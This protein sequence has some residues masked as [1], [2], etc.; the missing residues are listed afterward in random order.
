MSGGYFDHL[1]WNV[2]DLA[3]RV[4]EKLLDIELHQ[5]DTNTVS[6][7]VNAVVLLKKAAVYAER[8]DYLLSGDDGE[9]S[10]HERLADD[11]SNIETPS[12]T[13]TGMEHIYRVD[14]YGDDDI[15]LNGVTR[16]RNLIGGRTKD[17]ARNKVF[18]MFQ[19][20]TGYKTLDFMNHYMYELKSHLTNSDSYGS[21]G[22][23]E[24]CVQYYHLGERT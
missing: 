6:E 19:E 16:Y 2:E 18:K 4:E 15:F 17:E 9:E 14:F 24:I 5:F 22:N 8:I 1:Q 21:Y 3:N 13:Y 20:M 11:L 23:W 10:F 7:F 12:V